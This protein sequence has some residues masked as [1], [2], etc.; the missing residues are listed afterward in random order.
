M[1]EINRKL[2]F[3]TFLKLAM[4]MKRETLNSSKIKILVMQENPSIYPSTYVRR[5]QRVGSLINVGAT[6]NPIH[7]ANFE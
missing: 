6:E 7:F 2:Q 3:S 4:D 5:S 1:N